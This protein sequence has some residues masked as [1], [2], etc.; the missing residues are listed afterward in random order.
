MSDYSKYRCIKVEKD[1]KLAT[2][3]LNR[4]EALNAVN[5]DLH[6]ELEH[7]WI[8]IASDSDVYAVMLTGAGKAFS[9]GGDVKNMAARWGTAEGSQWLRRTAPAGR[10]IIE[11]MLD[12][13]QP[14]VSAVNGDAMGLGA[15]L[16]LMCDVIVAS[17]TARIADT[18]VKVGIVAGDSGAV[19]WP[20]L[21]GPA[22]AKEFLMRGTMLT[23]A[24]AAR[25]GLVNYAVPAGEVVAKAHSIA[26]E[27]ADGPTF[28]IRWS[29]L[30]VNKWLKQ[31]VNLILD[32][33]LAYEMMTFYTE[34]H[35]EAATAF[36]EKRKPTF[37]GK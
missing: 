26:R 5:Q 21:V 33:S 14:I 10:R 32:A 12:V 27:L 19:I 28:A 8:D 2:V 29:K 6:D 9:A 24:D 1:N 3:T 22:R 31:Q 15:N 36:A 35:K 13:E 34:D 4:P 23:G 25:I 18:H 17:E 7:I 20:L 11:R 37:K 16:A 30:A